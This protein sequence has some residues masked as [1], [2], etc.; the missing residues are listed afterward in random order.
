MDKELERI[1]N[2]KLTVTIQMDKVAWKRAIICGW[3]DAFGES[4]QADDVK[5][6][7]N[8][9]DFIRAVPYLSERNIASIIVR[10]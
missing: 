4:I 7:D 10:D 1:G 6:I 2:M 5:L 8:P 3:K 9:S